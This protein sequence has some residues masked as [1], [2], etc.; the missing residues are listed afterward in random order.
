VSVATPWCSLQVAAAN[1][2]DGSTVLVRGGTYPSTTF[3]QIRHVTKV[4]LQAYS[5]EMP[6]TGY[7]V[8]EDSSGLRL[9]GFHFSGTVDLWPGSNGDIELVGNESSNF[10]DI[11][12]NI[13]PGAS[14]VLV[15][16][17]YIH[18]LAARSSGGDAGTA[19]EASGYSAP[20]TGLR[21]VGNQI[22]R[23]QV[24]GVHLGGGTPSAVVDSNEIAWIGPPPP[25]SGLHTDP[26]IVQGAS[27]L[28]VKGNSFHDNYAA[29]L[30]FNGVQG[31]D[32]ENNLVVNGANYGL[33]FQGSAPNLVFKF[34]TVWGNSFGGVLFEGPSG[35]GSGEIIHNNVLQA[36]NVAAGALTG[37]DEDYNDVLAG[38][39]GASDVTTQ[40]QFVNPPSD[41]HVVAGSLPFPAGI[42]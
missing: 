16:G 11:G 15:Q 12:I 34:N 14:N 21:I 3:R 32:F 42:P 30:M 37:A 5:G 10:A 25:G 28:E 22:L 6:T 33:D 18:D 17:N 35:S 36:L 2:P 8:F 24:G 29:I 7:T 13:G 39:T 9:Q 31:V 27:G 41:Y 4:T 38:G 26:L 20:I 40:P 23:D 1:A 19:V